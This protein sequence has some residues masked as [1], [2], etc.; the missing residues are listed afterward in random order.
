[1]KRHLIATVALLLAAAPAL[2][3]APAPVA[4]PIGIFPKEVR[5]PEASE[6]LTVTP[7]EIAPPPEDAF[8][9]IYLG[10][11]W[12]FWVRARVRVGGKSLAGQW[13]AYADKVFTFLDRDG[14]GR[15]S[16][17]E[18]ERGP[19]AVTLQQWMNGNVFLAQNGTA[20]AV[21][22]DTDKDGSVSKAEWRM[23]CRPAVAQL[24]VAQPVNASPFNPEAVNFG[25]LARLDTD[26]DGRLS[27]AEAEALPA[28]L[29][30][31]DLDEDECLTVQEL[32]P[33]IFTRPVRQPANARP[34]PGALFGNTFVTPA[35]VMPDALRRTLLQR[36]D[37]DGDRL[38][39]LAESGLDLAA[40]DR[41]D[42]DANGLLDAIELS[43]WLSGDPAVAVVVD[44]EAPG[45]P[46]R[47][48][49]DPTTR[50]WAT[51][52]L[53]ESEGS[54]VAL[55]VGG[56]P[57]ELASTANTNPFNRDATRNLIPFFRSMDT[58]MK[59]YL[60]AK[61][62]EA[63]RNRNF[64]QPIFRLGDRDGDGKFTEKEFVA[65]AELS[66]EAG[67]MVA[68]AL[69]TVRQEG[70]FDR[71]DRDRDGRL[72]LRELRNGWSA[73]A[74]N[75]AALALTPPGKTVAFTLVPGRTFGPQPA[76]GRF[77]GGPI[78]AQ[79]KGPLWFRKL[80]RNADGDISPAEFRGPLEAFR[81]LD[82]DGDG[83]ISLAEAEQAGT[84]RK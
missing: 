37:R 8:D 12:A 51:A 18:V 45:S 73:L 48:A 15:L 23:A 71:V 27:R 29:A 10:D 54:K 78:P 3:Q 1:V 34:I 66:A 84:A 26:K 59:G 42:T 56:M 43:E 61:E 75:G 30:R 77:A 24:L 20:K 47:L 25:L 44:L 5:P 17:D 22:V 28:L 58:G 74:G 46:A 13:D 80:D 16:T 76:A 67:G 63:S 70:W 38:L 39:N 57:L 82:R 36:Y 19:N 33:D 52:E 65:V 35:G 40:F 11:D 7:K 64:I 72:G 62:V 53:L 2:A 32:V 14:D 81:K 31:L 4:E 69:M 50:R 83:L 68:T 9:L 21:A 41:L 6:R 60:D 79:T 49:V 55:R